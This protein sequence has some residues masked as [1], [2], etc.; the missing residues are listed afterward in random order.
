MMVTTKTTTKVT[1]ATIK[2]ATKTE[3]AAAKKTV[4]TV[5][6]PVK[7][8]EA[9]Q[10]TFGDALAVEDESRRTGDTRSQ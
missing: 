8:V 5:K 7:P 3:I 2:K 9:E 4:A 10:L 1:K 6:K